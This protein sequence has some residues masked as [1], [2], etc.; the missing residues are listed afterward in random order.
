MCSETDDAMFLFR[1]EGRCV[2]L[3]DCG[4]M[5]GEQQIQRSG[6]ASCLVKRA[7]KNR[8]CFRELVLRDS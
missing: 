5:A 1:V 4:K 3:C 6:I 7:Q 2:V 8:L